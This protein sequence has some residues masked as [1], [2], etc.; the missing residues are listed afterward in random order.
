MLSPVVLVV[1]YC[2]CCCNCC[3]RRRRGCCR[4]FLELVREAWRDGL[5]GQ[6]EHNNKPMWAGICCRL[7]GWLMMVEVHALEDS[8]VTS[9]HDVDKNLHERNYRC[10]EIPCSLSEFSNIF[11]SSFH[12]GGFRWIIPFSRSKKFDNTMV[13]RRL[14]CRWPEH[15]LNW[16]SQPDGRECPKRQSTDK[17]RIQA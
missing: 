13:Y 12:T 8:R 17:D 7:G 9:T 2:Q 16:I 4:C 10:V 6:R 14:S 5:V 1:W 3:R 15:L 11:H